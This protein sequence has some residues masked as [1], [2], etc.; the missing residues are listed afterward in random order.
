[1]AS[2]PSKAWPPGTN[3][4]PPPRQPRRESSRAAKGDCSRKRRFC[5]PLGR[6]AYYAASRS[7]RFSRRMFGEDP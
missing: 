4:D 2:T 6:R 1:M 3:P 5:G 7:K